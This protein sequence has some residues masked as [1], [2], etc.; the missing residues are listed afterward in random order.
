[1]DRR[2]TQINAESENGD[3]VLSFP[4]S[5][6]RLNEFIKS[7][8]EA[9]RKSGLNALRNNLNSRGGIPGDLTQWYI[10]GVDCELLKP[11][12]GW[13]KGKIKINISLEFSPDE[14]EI[15]EIPVNNQVNTNQP[16]S[17]LDDIRRAINQNT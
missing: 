5:M 4:H 11:G 14:P 6:F 12:K 17:P 1:M 15:E 7:V 9:L 16:E 10:Q 3:T 13:K 8:Q 2:F